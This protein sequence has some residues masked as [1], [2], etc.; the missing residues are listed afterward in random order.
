MKLLIV[1]GLLTIGIAV[2]GSVTISMMQENVDEQSEVVQ[3]PVDIQTLDDDQYPS[4]TDAVQDINNLV[5]QDPPINM[6]IS[7]VIDETVPLPALSIYGN[8]SQSGTR[9]HQSIND[10]VLRG[11][12]EKTSILNVIDQAI[13]NDTVNLLSPEALTST[14]R[15]KATVL[16]FMAKMIEANDLFLATKLS[17]EDKP[18]DTVNIINAGVVL[19]PDFAQEV[20]NA[21]VITGEID[22]SEALLAALAA[23][24]D[25]TTVS[26]ATAAGGAVARAGLPIDGLGGGGNGNDDPSAS[27]N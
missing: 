21:A 27:N 26:E 24:A 8:Q 10:L 19:Y 12:P 11:T 2:A 5:L 20:I 15:N 14:K 23:G 17:I 16:A 6:P 7:N 13:T 4:G 9:V 22:S 1:G 3:S 18:D 25:P